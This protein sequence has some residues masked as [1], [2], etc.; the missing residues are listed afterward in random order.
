MG[1]LDRLLD[2]WARG[3]IERLPEEFKPG[4]HG[5]GSMWSYD[6]CRF[7]KHRRCMYAKELN[8]AATEEAGYAVWVPVDRGLCPRDKWEDQKKCPV[9]EPGPHSGEPNARIDATVAWEDGGQ[10]GGIPQPS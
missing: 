2:P 9:A 3:V 10:R 1:I 8:V 5:E 4:A 6:W 7:R